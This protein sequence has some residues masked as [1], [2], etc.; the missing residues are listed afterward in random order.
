[1]VVI[2]AT[3]GQ[4]RLTFAHCTVRIWFLGDVSAREA[5]V[6]TSKESGGLSAEQLEAMEKRREEL[7]ERIRTIDP[8]TLHGL[9]LST[10]A[11]SSSAVVTGDFHDYW[12]KSDGGFTEVW[13][14]VRPQLDEEEESE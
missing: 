14:K 12:F 7:L 8:A 6:A 13:K 10:G 1:L 4:R 2:V 3:S 9:M 5:F 11:A